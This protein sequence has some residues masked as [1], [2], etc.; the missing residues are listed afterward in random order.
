MK[1]VILMAKV[2]GLGAEGDVVQV[3]DGYARNF[4]LPRKKAS[5]VTEASRRQVEK[6]REERIER[7]K[8]ELAAAAQTAQKLQSV[9]C[10]IAVKTGE[11]GKMFGSVTAADIAANLK[12]QGIEVDRH[13]VQLKEAIKELGV[14]DIELK[15]HS[16]V[17]ATIKVWV[18]E[19]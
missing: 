17:S 5:L 16:D 2:D 7:E 1:E 4:L 15:L 11:G 9:S 14:F 13:A 12:E 6:K 10:T 19:E 3:A 8:N 18:V